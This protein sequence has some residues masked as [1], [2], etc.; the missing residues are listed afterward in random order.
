MVG[1][2]VGMCHIL[3]DEDARYSQSLLSLW[4]QMGPRQWV[5]TNFFN[6]SCGRFG[7]SPGPVTPQLSVHSL[8]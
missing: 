5:G 8:T 1:H 6:S 4:E 7:V 2:G 3:W